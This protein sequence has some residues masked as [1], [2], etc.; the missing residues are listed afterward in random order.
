MR[1]DN[2][3][4]PDDG[5]PGHDDE[6][7]PT[8]NDER[9]PQATTAGWMPWGVGWGWGTSYL[10]WYSRNADEPVEETDTDNSD[11]SHW[12]EGIFS[13]LLIAG[14]ILFIFPEPI[15]SFVG[16]LLLLTGAVGWLISKL[17]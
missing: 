9:S 17:I 8:Y 6:R 3:P 5:D 2:R 16:I 12:G 1:S 4:R 7:D 13:L 14:V 11:E 10:P 15:T